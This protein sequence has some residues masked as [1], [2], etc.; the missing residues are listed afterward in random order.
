MATEERSA[1]HRR[2]QA[3]ALLG[4][5][6]RGGSGRLTLFLGAAPGVG[7][8][9][10]MLSRARELKKQ[11]ID[12]VVGL[13][14]THGRI[15]TQALLE[16]LELLPRTRLDYQGRPMEE[17]DLD[18]LLARKPRIALVDELAHRN[19]PGSRHER[20]WQDVIELLDAGIDVY[21]TVN[22]QHLESLNDVVHRIT[23]VRVSETV[24]DLVFDRLRDIKLIDLPPRELIERLQQGKVYVPDQAAH[25]LQAFF[26]PSNLTALRELAMQ[27]AADRVDSDLRESQAARGVP[28]IALRRRVLVAIDGQGQS[29]YLVRVARRLAERRDA[30]WGVVTVQT[31]RVADAAQQLELDRAFALARRLGGDAEVVHGASI[32]DA[33]LDHASRTG[34][35]T[36]VLGRTRER[37]VARMF[38]QTLTQQLLQRGAH[39]ELTIFA[40]PEARA[41]SRR[42][43]REFGRRMTRSDIGL[44]V[45][46][47]IFATIA[48]A[49]AERWVGLDDLS[50]VFIV[51]VVVVASRTRMSAAVL[52]A[53]LCFLSYN[54]FFID[55]RFTLMIGGRQGVATVLMFLLAALV[56]GRLASRLRT[57]IVALRAA[58]AHV[59]A[60]QALSRQLAVAADLGQVMAAGRQALKQATGADALVH[61]G[62]A[63]LPDDGPQV[64]S[65]K[66]R[67]A[68][69]WS[70][71]HRQEAGRH[72]D[73]LGNAAWWFRPLSTDGDADGLIG[74]RFAEDAPRAGPEQARLIEAMADDIAQAVV[75]ARL[76]ADL[77]DARVSGETERLRSALLSSVSHDLRSPLASIIGA[78]ESL[79]HYADAMSADDRRSLLDTVRT[80]GERLD[81]YVQNLLDMTRLGHGGLTLNRDWIGVDE[82]VGS[83]VGRLQ[84]YQPEAKFDLRFTPGLA[85]IWVHPALVEQALFN[86]IENA[87]KF[88]PPGEAIIVDASDIDG[89]L[90]VDVTDRGP[91]IPDDER[92][93]IFDMF[94]SVE[95]GDRGRQ[96]T[97]LG[98]AITQGMVG[99][100]GGSVDAL[101]GPNGR[102]TT[103]RITL[104]RLTP[105]TPA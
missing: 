8:T 19:V 74:L 53:A 79:E 2:E 47:A 90:R 12:V 32:A 27:T 30:P 63:P 21:T 104:P 88:S 6:Q 36:I 26:S 89:R 75:R 70:L 40:T 64:F 43:V 51:A 50:M 94:Y 69:D 4:E 24:P 58:N 99:A 86:V 103:I 48:G 55:P 101:P 28:G 31:G 78:A 67:A 62:N 66:D 11:G 82:L 105:P 100:H 49:I 98:L 59:T 22:I 5:I 87:V 56:A 44:A 83:A 10:A 9:Y 14:E 34:V 35:S 71:R 85:P 65:E 45:L 38:N 23:G 72:T 52:A 25:A 13:V 20:R 76:V 61:V 39:Y 33:I 91:G 68:A 1:T 96:G 60:L 41:K 57:Q 92:E 37:P 54:F 93:R 42:S 95:R 46:S 3:D 15:E 102:G 7:K 29:E 97:G 73:T 84:R 17:L 81:R 16:G 77:E 80:E 18:A